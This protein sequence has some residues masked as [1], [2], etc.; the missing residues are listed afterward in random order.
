VAG[1]ADAFCIALDQDA[2]YASPNFQW[3]RARF[4]RFVYVDR[5]V[6]ARGAHGRGLGRMLY[7]ALTEA[8]RESGHDRICAEINA[9]PPNPASDRFHAAFGFTEIGRAELADSGKTVRYVS[10]S[11]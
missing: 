5:V 1:A 9:V 6:V 8:A 7:R 3:F 4:P 2:T 11:L 10:L